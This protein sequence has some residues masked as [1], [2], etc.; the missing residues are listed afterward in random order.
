ML[1]SMSYDGI[2]TLLIR[3]TALSVITMEVVG[4]FATMVLGAKTSLAGVAVYMI[5]ALF[6]LVLSRPIGKLIASGLDR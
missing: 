5:T 6:L 2:A 4:I 1:Q 3:F